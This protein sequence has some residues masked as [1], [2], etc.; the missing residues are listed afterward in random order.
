MRPAVTAPEPKPGSDDPAVAYGDAVLEDD[1]DS[2]FAHPAIVK[3][4]QL[5][6]ATEHL[7]AVCVRADRLQDVELSGKLAGDVLARDLA[8]LREAAFGVPVFAVYD[9]GVQVFGFGELA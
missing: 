4:E 2:R 1:Q 7:V 3:D 5:G 9:S 6:A 8:R